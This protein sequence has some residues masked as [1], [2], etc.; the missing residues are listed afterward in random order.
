MFF[1]INAVKRGVFRI[2]LTK[3]ELNLIMPYEFWR[4]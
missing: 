4:G 3:K 2:I 1:R